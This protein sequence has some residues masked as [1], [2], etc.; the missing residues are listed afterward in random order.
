MDINDEFETCHVYIDELINCLIDNYTG[1]EVPTIARRIDV[2]QL[3]DCSEKENWYIDWSTWEEDVEIYALYVDGSDTIE[4]L[5][6]LS[7]NDTFSSADIKWMCAAPHNNYELVGNNKQYNGVGGH[8][9]AIAVEKSLEW[10]HDGGC[11]LNAATEDLVNHYVDY[12][13]IFVG[14]R[15]PYHM[16]L[17]GVIGKDLTN[18][19]TLTMQPI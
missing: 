19:Y 6:A 15:H 12:G 14:I 11:V 3:A 5:I 2:T 1:E 18:I 7:N 13:F 8:L 4:G 9:F 17:P 16:V 10:E